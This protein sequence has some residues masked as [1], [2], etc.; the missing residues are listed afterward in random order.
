MMVEFIGRQTEL[1]VLADRFAKVTSGGQCLL[2]RGRRRIG[3]SRLIEE[4]IDRGG[5]PSLYFTAAGG[6]S[7][8]ELRR[9]S[10]DAA[11][12][13]LA[14][15]NL[16]EAANPSS[17]DAALQVLAAALPDDVPSVVV[18]DEL[19]YLM[20]DQHVFEG[21]LQRSW[22]RHLSR[23]PILLILI[24]SD[25]SMMEALNDY[26]RPFHQRGREMV[27]GPLNPAD[28]AALLGLAPADAIDAA[29]VTGG[30]PLI[31]AEWPAGAG[32]NE[33]L[34]TVLNDPTSAL[35]VSAERS[36]AAEFPSQ[37]QARAVLRAIGSG[38]RTFANVARAAGGLGAAPLQRSLTLLADKRL[39]VGELPISLRPSR[40]RRYRVTDP[41]LRFWL[42]FLA[43]H[44]DEIERGR[45]DRTLDRVR[46]GWATWR[47]RAVEPLVREALARLLPDG[48]LP[49]A[50]AIGGYWT[51]TN[52]VEIDL[53]GADR[54]PI[55]KELRFV[56]SIKWLDQA[57][58]DAHD[59][60]A[61]QR[62]RFALT[63][64][65]VPLV[66]V[67][68]AGVSCGGLDA[69]YGPAELLAA[70]STSP[71]PRSTHGD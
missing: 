71:D 41:Y 10:S 45:G 65:Q 69:V 68:R 33:F 51:R 29:L 30:L 50:E 55:A 22:D 32:V 31:A 63:A 43:A 16:I 46:R 42:H 13:T 54:A 38:E 62:H 49:A 58:F 24:G 12:S 25:I 14:G 19:P 61:L 4:F 60:T 64:E 3:K 57:T 70:W 21:V 2:V 26:G 5:M 52:D 47:G 8:D 23:K 36:L 37:I 27:V 11:D 17:W 20:D 59:L 7:A 35:L 6:P 1:K 40:D 66:A 28:L 56:G 67:S 44:T 9:F 39:V 34:A 48:R 53:V 18:I 15:R